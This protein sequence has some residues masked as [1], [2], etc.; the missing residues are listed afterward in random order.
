MYQTALPLPS[1]N[2]INVLRAAFVQADPKSVKKTDNLTVFYT[3]LGSEH[4]KAAHRTLMKLTPNFCL[5]ANLL[6]AICLNHFLKISYTI[7]VSNQKRTNFFKPYEFLKT[8]L[9]LRPEQVDSRILQNGS[10]GQDFSGM[11]KNTEECGGPADNFFH[12]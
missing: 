8:I 9:I 10:I 12:V 7:I 2:F 1:V 11:T 6:G 5:Q 3:L 4:S